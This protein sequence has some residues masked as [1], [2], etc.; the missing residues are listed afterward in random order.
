MKKH[1]LFILLA[2]VI[3]LVGGEQV[4]SA[5]TM[6]AT[7]AITV[8]K[9]QYTG[10][11][12]D[13]TIPN[14]GLAKD[15]IPDGFESYNP[16]INGQVEFTLVDVTDYVAT[17]GVDQTQTDLITLKPSDYPTWITTN[18]TKVGTKAVNE[19]GLATFNKVDS[20]LKDGA[21]RHY[22]VFETQTPESVKTPA[23]PVLVQ[24]PMT[25]REGTGF[26]DTVFIYPKNQLGDTPDVEKQIV[27]PEGEL[28]TGTPS[29][30]IGDDV[31]YS[32]TINVPT[33][34]ADYVLFDYNDQGQTG[35]TY[36]GSEQQKP[37][38][39]GTSTAVEAEEFA[40][41]EGTDYLYTKVDNGFK[42]DFIVNGE[43]SAKVASIN[44]GTIA[45]AYSMTLNDEAVID[46]PID[47]DYVLTWQ[48][49]P[50]ADKQTKPG[51]T[52]VYTGGMK[53][54]KKDG[55]DDHALSGAQFVIKNTE[56]EYYQG[57]AEGAVVWGEKAT[58]TIFTSDKSGAFEITGLEYGT[59]YLEETK[60][61]EGY[62]L[63]TK[64]V[65]FVISKDSYTE[66]EVTIKNYKK[67]LLPQTG[68][69]QLISVVIIG[70]GLV[71]W[72]GLYYKK[73]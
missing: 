6:P 46:E 58:A 19:N 27:N 11:N 14:D 33:D 38:L 67:T 50:T 21:Y 42:I 23:Q 5:E 68:S 59:Y 10:P 36:T 64:P 71:F 22:V 49:S 72:G 34:V 31:H 62:A 65:E 28:V 56:D 20:V 3:G 2:V 70:I 30:S 17:N 25:N 54:I 8:H 48:N 61:P 1:V 73:R 44:G 55:K 57:V 39:T 43:I 24:L 63:H 66:K 4:A 29:Y 26:L 60:A 35:L 15:A 40:L 12:Q 45:I 47:N 32:V 16:T 9:L 51:S 37:K 52:S 69:I 53:F 13:A 7:T 18:G 41:V